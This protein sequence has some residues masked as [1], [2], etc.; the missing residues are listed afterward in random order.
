[1]QRGKRVSHMSGKLRWQLVALVAEGAVVALVVLMYF[2]MTF[3]WFSSNKDVSG[4]G[5]DSVTEIMDLHAKYTTYRYDVYTNNEVRTEESLKDV[6]FFPYDELFKLRNRYTSL[7]V[8]AELTGETLRPEGGTVY[9]S[10][11]RNPACEKMKTDPKTGREE[12][13]DFAS[14]IMRFTIAVDHGEGNLTTGSGT[15]LLPPAPAD[16]TPDPAT[17]RT[18]E[19]EFAWLLYNGLDQ[20]M[21]G[22]QTFYDMVQDLVGD[23]KDRYE[24]KINDLKAGTVGDSKVFTTVETV[25]NSE[26]FTYSKEDSIEVAVDY[27]TGDLRVTPE[28]QKCLNVFLFISYDKPL[29]QHFWQYCINDIELNPSGDGGAA[30]G[31]PSGGG[32]GEGGGTSGGGTTEENNFIREIRMANDFTAVTVNIKTPESDPAQP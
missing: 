6:Q 19:Q 17:G 25:P 23:S 31:E 7:I 21:V 9:F 20:A 15:G 32:T 5:I 30:G 18:Q 16:L 3:G 29:V 10:I 1:M 27:T 12:P 4:E 11:G 22:N 8:R 24:L 14:S 26:E 2:G 28:G 13:S